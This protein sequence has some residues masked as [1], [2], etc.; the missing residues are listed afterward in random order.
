M[1]HSQCGFI[2]SQS[3]KQK[4]N[5]KRLGL[6]IAN[7]GTNKT[8]VVYEHFMVLLECQETVIYGA[9][10]SQTSYLV[11]H[12]SDDRESY[13]EVLTRETVSAVKEKPHSRFCLDKKTCLI[14]GVAC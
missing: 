4:P 11:R 5:L 2:H 3:Q 9:S 12:K 6:I 8:R 1:P 14:T 10:I 7:Q 13:A